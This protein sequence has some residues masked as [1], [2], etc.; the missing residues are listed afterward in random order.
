[1]LVAISVENQRADTKL[2][3]QAV[4]IKL[5]LLLAD[6]RIALGAFGLD[7]GKRFAIIAPQ[8][9]IGKAIA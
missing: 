1:M 4:G 9:I 8:H 7:D 2:G 6:T 3:L 5:C